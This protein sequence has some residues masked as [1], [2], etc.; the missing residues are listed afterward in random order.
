MSKPLIQSC[1]DIIQTVANIDQP[2]AKSP[3]RL[4]PIEG[5][6]IEQSVQDLSEYKGWIN[7]IYFDSIDGSCHDEEVK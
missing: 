6:V 2:L 7:Q 5:R 4:P 1:L 3:N